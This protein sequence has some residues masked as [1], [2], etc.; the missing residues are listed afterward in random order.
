MQP[1]E[2]VN[3]ET[4][5]IVS[6]ESSKL[7]TKQNDAAT[8]TLSDFLKNKDIPHKHLL[9]CYDGQEEASFL[10]VGNEHER[11]V[12][13]I[14]NMFGQSSY[15]KSLPSRESFLIKID[16]TVEPLGKLIA[17]SETEAK[18]LKSWSYCFELKQYYTTRK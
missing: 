9:G 7:G 10:I 6:A 16:G 17:V 14:A 12:A 8:N 3:K 4:I 2:Q 18:R 11:L 15:F 1:I 13:S 5:F